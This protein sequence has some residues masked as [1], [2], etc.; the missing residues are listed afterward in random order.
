MITELAGRKILIV[1]AH[2]DDEVLGCGASVA[3]WTR[4]GA[5]V[6]IGILGEGLTSRKEAVEPA[7][8]DALH[9]T[10]R[11]AAALLGAR[12]FFSTRFPDNRFDTVP[13]LDLVRVVEG[14]VERT[15][16]DVVF[17]HHPGDLNIDHA[18][19]HRAVL[20]ATRPGGTVRSVFAFEIHSSTEWAFGQFAAF[21]P[22]VFLDVSA[23][24]DAKIQALGLYDGEM[25]RFPHPR[26]AEALRS[27]A[28]R[29]GAA[30]GLPAAEA[31][32]LV[33]AVG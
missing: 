27:S 13:L 19:T 30:A 17:T 25:R 23:T 24:L 22:N 20:T 7:A 28:L 11:R 21:R 10:A 29:W 8:I 31:F 1:A 26:S 14:W 9:D 4:G 15:Q 32:E 6:S 5:D 16:P 2:P 18:L 3:R 33:R 12:A